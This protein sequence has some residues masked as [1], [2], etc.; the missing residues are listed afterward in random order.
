MPFSSMIQEMKGEIGAIS[1]RGLLRS[2]SHRAGSVRR[3]EA[4]EPDEAA[5]RE[6]S[7]AQVPPEILRE[8]LAKVEA[9]E[10]RWP[11]RAAVVACAGVCRGW[12]GAIKEIVRVPEACGKLTFP[13]S[14]KQPG[15]RDVLI[16]CFIRR[17]RAMQSYF[18][19]I[20]VTDGLTD[21]GKFLL[22]ARKYRRPSC[23]EYLISLD[24]SD[25]SKGHGTYIGKLRSNFLGTKFVVYD[26]HPPCAG[27]V[28]SKGPSAHIIGSAQVSPM[29]PPPA[30]NYPVSRISYDVNILGSRGP[31]K[32]NCVMDSIPVSA[33]KEG[34]SAPTQTEFPSSNSS[35]FAPIPFFGSKSGQVDNSGA[36]L[37]TENESKVALKNK[38]PR[39][40][41]QLQGWCL[42]FHGRVMVASVK[43][44]QL[45]ASG[46]TTPTPSNQED[47][48]VILQFGKIGKDLFSMDYR[49][50][51]SAFEA[52][53]ICLSSFDTKIGCE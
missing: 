14:L 9:M 27:A 41:E 51:I 36:Q 24:A 4:A 42:N 8:V 6:S 49:Y 25:K 19:C 45:V 23:T 29:K 13:I 12:R 52:F 46:V 15:P 33:I 37:A 50:P 21:D 39:W 18:L 20:G 34:G 28:V 16:K 22:A 44:F 35:S 5:M 43:N 40:H 17:N 1:R 10:A 32:M 7:W 53:A 47:D 11:G 38:S 2:R 30:G 26:A 48:D 3:G 31:R